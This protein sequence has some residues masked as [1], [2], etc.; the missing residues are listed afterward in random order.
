MGGIDRYWQWDSAFSS[1]PPPVLSSS[2]CL[3]YSSNNTFIYT[4]ITT[5]IYLHLYVIYV[6]TWS[7]CENSL[8]LACLSSSSS[9]S[10]QNME[11]CDGYSAPSGFRYFSRTL[12]QHNTHNH[13][14]TITSLPNSPACQ[15]LCPACLLSIKVAYLRSESSMDSLSRK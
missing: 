3:V 9:T 7:A 12:S 1:L 2:V 14:V 4:S 11:Q 6:S 13:T 15:C 10:A 5:H 8:A